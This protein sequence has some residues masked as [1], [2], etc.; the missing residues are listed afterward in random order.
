MQVLKTGWSASNAAKKKKKLFS[1]AALFV[2]ASNP[3]DGTGSCPVLIQSKSPRV[4]F[5]LRDVGEPVCASIH[6]A[7]TCFYGHL[8][9]SKTAGILWL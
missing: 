8:V 4:V 7:P 2:R 9:D 6:W 3:R 1:H 5:L